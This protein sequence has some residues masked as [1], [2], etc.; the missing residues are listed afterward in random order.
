MKKLLFIGAILSLITSSAFATRKGSINFDEYERTIGTIAAEAAALTDVYFACSN[1]GIT[2][3]S[4]YGVSFNC[5]AAIL[6]AL[7]LG[8]SEEEIVEAAQPKKSRMSDELPM[9]DELRELDI[10]IEEDLRNL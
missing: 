1:E 5:E 2:K 9:S 3:A 4:A 7:E 8:I 10:L 6:S